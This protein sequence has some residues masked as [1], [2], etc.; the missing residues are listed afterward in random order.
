[1]FRSGLMLN[2]VGV[3]LGFVPWVIISIIGLPLNIIAVGVIWPVAGTAM[4]AGLALCLSGPAAWA[5][6]LR[7]HAPAIAVLVI[8]GALVPEF[9]AAL[10]GLWSVE[11]NTGITFTGVLAVLYALGYPVTAEVATKEIAHEDFAVLDGPQCSGVEGF[12]LITLFTAVFLALSRRDLRFPHVLLLF[13]V[14]LALSWA[15]NVLRISVLLVIGIEVSPELAVGGF[16]SHAGWLAFTLLSVGIIALAYRVP[17]FRTTAASPAPA[18]AAV[19]PPLHADPVAACILPFV[20]FMASAL[21]VST[22][23][24]IPGLAYPL[25]ALVTGLALAMFWRVYMALPWRLDGL[26]VALGLGCGVLWVATAPGAETADSALAARLAELPAVLLVAWIACRIVGTVVI[27]PL[28][29]ELFFRGYLLERLDRGGMLG[30]VAA[31]VVTSVAFGVLHDRWL[32]GSLA[33]LLFGLVYFRRRNV[34]D[35][36]VSH[37]SANAVIAAVALMRGGWH[38]I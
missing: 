20:V 29:E 2:L 14:G 6:V 13:P 25:R 30:A 35:A 7:A 9:S 10:F 12:A 31:L 21:V 11:T 38:L 23:V 32:A 8:L 17:A 37:A 34:T 19:L 1:M 16:H 22:F 27:V 28:V 33:G 36:I 15:F 26:A 18:G 4:I 24:A 5:A 3:A